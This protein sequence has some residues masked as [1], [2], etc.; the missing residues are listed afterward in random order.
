MMGNIHFETTKQSQFQKPEFKALLSPNKSASSSPLF[1]F[2][3]G[4][5]EN[6]QCRL[7]FNIKPKAKWKGGRS[8]YI[9]AD[10]DG[11]EVAVE[12]VKKLVVTVP[13]KREMRDVLVALWVLRLWFDT[14]E[15][16]Q[17]RR[18]GM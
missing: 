6:Q 7:L 3:D 9:W 2:S 15:S 5:T 12:E 14:A 8:R 13:M 10:A 4:E 1:F 17:A 11:R 18:E 16:R